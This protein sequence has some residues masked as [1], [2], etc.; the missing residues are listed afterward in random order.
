[1]IPNIEQYRTTTVLL[2]CKNI[3]EE[4]NYGATPILADALQD[5]DFADESIL[6]ALRASDAPLTTLWKLVAQIY[7]DE[8]AAA[9]KWMEEFV[10]QLKENPWAPDEY[11]GDLD[12][13]YD[14]LLNTAKEY[15]DTGDV[16]TQY[17]MSWQRTLD[18][19]EEEFWENYELLTGTKV[20]DHSGHFFSCTC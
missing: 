17:G 14:K 1:M 6:T 7:T 18:G 2:V 4:Q 12:M 10:G 9:V 16:L 8:S 19:N 15:I 3:R 5:A 20:E 13:T 11:D